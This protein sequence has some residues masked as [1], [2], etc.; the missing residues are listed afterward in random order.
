MRNLVR[1]TN[2]YNRLQARDDWAQLAA[3]AQANGHGADAERLQ[4]ADGATWRTIDK[5]I[6]ALM[7]AMG[8]TVTFQQ[9]QTQQEATR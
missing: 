5:R 8:I 3:Y 4:P 1:I 6:D 2:Y 7:A 9:W